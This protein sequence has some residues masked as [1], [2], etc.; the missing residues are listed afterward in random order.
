MSEPHF[1]TGVTFSFF[2]MNKGSAVYLGS[3]TKSVSD[4]R[5]A[6]FSLIILAKNGAQLFWELG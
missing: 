6:L 4:N 3:H 5:P 2:A 1:C